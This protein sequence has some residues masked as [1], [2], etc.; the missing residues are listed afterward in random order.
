MRDAMITPI[1]RKTFLSVQKNIGQH[2]I[3][4]I[5]RVTYQMDEYTNQAQVVLWSTTWWVDSVIM[6]CMLP[7]NSVTRFS[8]H[9][10]EVLRYDQVTD[11]PLS[12]QWLLE[13]AHGY[14]HDDLE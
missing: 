8:Q 1:S 12:A 3:R 9:N 6:S 4:T 14:G 11:S 10:G 5:D 7:N 2:S 13:C